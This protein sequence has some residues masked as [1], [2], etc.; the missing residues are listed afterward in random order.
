MP[1]DQIV[2]NLADNEMMLQN[3]SPEQVLMGG[4]A[5]GGGGADS[6]SCISLNV[7]PLDSQRFDDSYYFF[8][9][10]LPH[11]RMLS[12]ERRML[13]RIQMQELV[14]KEVYKKDEVSTEGDNGPSLP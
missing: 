14:Y 2:D 9:S 1:A 12:A 3:I 4:E 8:M 5:P 11:I 6:D 13:L 10:L 7:D